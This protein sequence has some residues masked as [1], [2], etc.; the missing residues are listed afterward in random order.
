MYGSNM[1]EQAHRFQMRL[2][3]HSMLTDDC[4][5][6]G[7]DIIQGGARYNYHS[8]AA[9][10]VPNAAD[11]IIA[12]QKTLFESNTISSEEMLNALKNNFEGMDDLRKYLM[13]KI[14]KYG[15]DINEVDEIAASLIE[16]YRSI[17]DEYRNPS[18]GKFFMRIFTFTLM[19]SLGKLTGASPDGR[20]AGEP[21]AYSISPGQGRD[22]EGFTA[23][24]NSLSRIPHHLAAASSSAILEAD[25]VMLEGKSRELFVDLITTAIDKG[26]GQMQF[27]VVNADTLR[28]AQNNPEKHPNLCVRV[29]GF[30]QQFS[31]LDREMQD[32]IIARVKH[33]R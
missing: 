25:P 29:S 23:V 2:P 14:P 19:L 13:N 8:T 7:L 6:N 15:N 33:T 4:I 31:L 21:L 28:D 9:T 10:G 18:G 3:Y 22:K 30:S 12:L 17:I 5:E 16:K 11:S 1:C 26:V 24:I 27:N 20:L 32:H